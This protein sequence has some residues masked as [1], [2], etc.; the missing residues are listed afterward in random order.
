LSIAQVQFVQVVAWAYYNVYIFIPKA[1]IFLCGK[2]HVRFLNQSGHLLGCCLQVRENVGILLNIV[3]GIL[4]GPMPLSKEMPSQRANHMDVEAPAMTAAQPIQEHQ[5]R[6]SSASETGQNLVL[7][8]NKIDGLDVAVSED[9][10]MST[11]AET[12]TMEEFKRTLIEEARISAVKIQSL[13]G[14]SFGGSSSAQTTTNGN[15]EL[16]V[17]DNRDAK[18]METVSSEIH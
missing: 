15:E 12:A 11:L 5:I 3:L 7:A 17:S 16:T 2:F 6:V 4:Q 14:P 13:G 10:E 1:T 18:W 8:A 9:G